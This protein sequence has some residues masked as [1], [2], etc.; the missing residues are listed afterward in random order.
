MERFCISF[1]MIN[2]VIENLKVL[3]SRVVSSLGQ[4]TKSKQPRFN[5]TKS[6]DACGSYRYNVNISP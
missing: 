6:K 2:K 1:D 3:K 5:R 4:W